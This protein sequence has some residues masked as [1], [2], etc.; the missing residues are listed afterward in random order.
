MS[1][2]NNHLDLKEVRRSQHLMMSRSFDDAFED[3]DN[4]NNKRR[5][6]KEN[7]TSRVE[8]I[9]HKAEEI[10]A[11]MKVKKAQLEKKRVKKRE[12]HQEMV[13]KKR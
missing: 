2:K 7:I 6:E 3:F 10:K 1:T 9:K 13:H 8:D 12:K 4:I 5:N 11:K